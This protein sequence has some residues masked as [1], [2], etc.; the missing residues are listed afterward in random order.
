V[1]LWKTKD[2]ELL[3]GIKVKNVGKV[4][5]ADAKPLATVARFAPLNKAFRCT[6]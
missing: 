2:K 4:E 1:G 3:W 5:P 6:E